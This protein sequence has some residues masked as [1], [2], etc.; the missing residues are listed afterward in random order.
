MT[1]L[2]SMTGYG[3]AEAQSL[4]YQI[5]VEIKSLNGKFLELNLRSPKIFSGHDVK[6]R[7]IFA[8]KLKRGSILFNIYLDRMEG[9]SEKVVLNKQLAKAYYKEFEAIKQELN[10]ENADLLRLVLEQPDVIKASETALDSKEIEAIFSCCEEAFKALDEY[11][12]IE[13]KS[14]SELLEAH[15]ERISEVLL[16]NLSEIEGERLDHVKSRLLNNLKEQ[17]L[18]GDVD[19]NRFEQEL[20]YYIEKIDIA[21]EKNRL[22]AHCIL[23]Y[24]ELNSNASGKKL[25]FISQEMGREINTL[26]SKA[27]Y[28][29][30]QRIVIDMKEELEQIKE[31]VLNVL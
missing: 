10:S 22:E 18:E 26:G 16:P 25:G 4:N 24:S 12:L 5:R 29:P 27:N 15:T 21:E 28:A 7:N 19:Q 11:R 2:R 23:F 3:N 8:N 31:Q 6:V 20:I 1:T 30:M 13:G 17:G 9:G 14:L